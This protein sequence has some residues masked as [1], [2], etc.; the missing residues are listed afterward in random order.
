MVKV[1]A[2]RLAWV[3]DSLISDSQFAFIKG[4]ILMGGVV[5]M[6]EIV[7]LARRSKSECLIFK[8]DFEKVYDSVSWRFL[9]Y[10]LCRFGFGNRWGRLMRAF[11]CSTV[12]WCW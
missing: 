10:I 11:A 4:R 5:S 9:D 7:D 6:N 12:F 8:V 2:A 3:M 1:L